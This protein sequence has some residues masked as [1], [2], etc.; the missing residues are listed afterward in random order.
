MQ[1]QP[2]PSSLESYLDNLKA[3][4]SDQRI[5]YTIESFKRSLRDIYDSYD[6]MASSVKSLPESL[7]FWFKGTNPPRTIVYNPDIMDDKDEIDWKPL[8]KDL[9]DKDDEK[10]RPG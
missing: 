9:E 4:L 8:L 5:H 2:P 7:Y 10:E 3:Y 6:I 1:A